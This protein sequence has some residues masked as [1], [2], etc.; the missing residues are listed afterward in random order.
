M[1]NVDFGLALATFTYDEA[2]KTYK[3][4]F[5]GEPQIDGRTGNT[6]SFT[7]VFVLET[8]ITADENGLHRDIDWSGGNGYYVSNGAVQKITWSKAA[9]SEPL[10]L[11]D[12]NGEE[13]TINR[14]KSYFGINYIGEATFE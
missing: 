7:N 6:L 12:E 2:S 3:K 5:N 11:Y 1:V 13:L 8:G 4:D 14:G 10:K 9:E